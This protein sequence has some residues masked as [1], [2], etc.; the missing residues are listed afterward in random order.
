MNRDQE[1]S[2]DSTLGLDPQTLKGTMDLLR[3]GLEPTRPSDELIK[4]LSKADGEKWFAEV[5]EQA[6]CRAIGLERILENDQ[7]PSLADLRKMKSA[8][9]ECFRGQSD[10]DDAR[11]GGLAGYFLVLAAGLRDHDELLSRQE[12]IVVAETFREL[13]VWVGEPWSDVLRAAMEQMGRRG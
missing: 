4:R 11:L 5:L 1:K 9:K 13:S 7:P 10:D 3:I 2:N 6:R 8:A 12:R